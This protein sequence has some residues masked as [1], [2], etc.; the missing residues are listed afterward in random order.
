MTEGVRIPP[1]MRA[2]A[3]AGVELLL[4]MIYTARSRAPLDLETLLIYLTV[5]EATMRPLMLDPST[6]PD[7]MNL[8]EPPEAYRGSITRLLAA[9]RLGLPRETVRRK[10]KKLVTMGLVQEDA[11]GRM[12]ATRNFANAD[13]Q[14]WV[15]ESF[16]AVQRYDA[17]LRQFGKAGVSGPKSTDDE[18]FP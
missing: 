14:S 3:Y 8:A 1:G 5:S 18:P 4:D 15:K 2:H 16:S 11:E 10:I 7:I 6:P 17:R 12:R 9:D 13:I